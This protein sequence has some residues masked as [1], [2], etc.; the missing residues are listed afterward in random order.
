MPRVWRQ[1]MMDISFVQCTTID[2][3][4][5]DNFLF[6]QNIDFMDKLQNVLISMSHKPFKKNM[7]IN[8]HVYYK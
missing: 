2:T 8:N 1:I 6:L 3:K 5:I 7:V 4:C